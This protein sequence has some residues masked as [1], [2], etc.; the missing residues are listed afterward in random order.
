VID[1]Y[2]SRTLE[3]LIFTTQ[4]LHKYRDS[5]V[6]VAGLPDPRKDHAEVMARFAHKCLVKTNT[7]MH[8]LETT[9][10]PGTSDLKMRIGLHRYVDLSLLA[11]L[12]TS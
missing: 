3:L 5:Y 4:L 9:L 12:C 2:L 7:L 10:G 11:F 8:A 1:F 6:A